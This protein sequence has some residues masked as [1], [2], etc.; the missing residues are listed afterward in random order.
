[1]K[2]NLNIKLWILFYRIKYCRNYYIIRAFNV[3]QSCDF[4]IG[5]RSKEQ[6]EK[7]MFFIRLRTFSQCRSHGL[8]YLYYFLKYHI[9]RP[10]YYIKR[11]F[12]MKWER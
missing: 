12:N 5:R 2:L 3:P 11:K 8:R 4:T 10:S 1:M 9:F 6:C 7:N